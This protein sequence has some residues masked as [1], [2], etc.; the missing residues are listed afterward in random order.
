MKESVRKLGRAVKGFF[1]ELMM[2]NDTP[3]G[4]A[5]GVAVGVFVGLTPTVG[6][7]MAIVAFISLFIRCNRTAGCAMVWISNPVTMV[8]LYYGNYLVGAGLLERFSGMQAMGWSDF[9]GDIAEAFIYPHWY[10]NMAAMILAFGRMTIDLAMPLWF[11]S[12][13]V[14]VVFSVPSYF[15]VLALVKRYRRRREPAQG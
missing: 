1:V 2:L 6:L 13:I 12:V 9:Y 8:P 10:E 14:A 11:G 3:H 4:I 7:Q 5:M 15:I